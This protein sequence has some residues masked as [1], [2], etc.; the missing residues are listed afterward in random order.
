MIIVASDHSSGMTFSGYATSKNYPVLGMDKFVS[1]VDRKPYQLITYSSGPGYFG[2]DEEMAKRD[3]RN[4]FHKATVPLSWANHAAE[5][6]PLFATG[7]FSSVL[8]GGTIDQ[9]YIAHAIAFAMCINDYTDRC[10]KEESFSQDS[11]KSLNNEYNVVK[12]E[13]NMHLFT[14]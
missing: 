6:V 4:S 5:D 10:S 13:F 7:M 1:N 2:Y 12:P 11:V 8:F 14:N 9:T 3:S